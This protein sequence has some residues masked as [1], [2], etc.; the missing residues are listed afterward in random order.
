MRRVHSTVII[1]SLIILAAGLTQFPSKVSSASPFGG[2]EDVRYSEKLWKALT[3]ARLVGKQSITA[4][5]YAGSVHKTILISLD[6]TVRV[7]SHTGVVIVK[8]MYQGP[9][10]SVQEVLNDPAKNLKIVAVMYK[11]E[12][13]YDSDN[14][15]WFYTKYNPDGTSQENDKGMLMTGRAAKCI[16]CHASAP[17]NDYI[18]SFDR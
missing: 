17:G 14:Q 12:R 16:S 13:G 10:V 11:R 9:D 1:L 15:D 18:Y 2:P 6:S 8:K 7:G 4:M 3:D 5:P